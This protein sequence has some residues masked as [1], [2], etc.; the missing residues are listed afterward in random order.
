PPASHQLPS[1]KRLAT[2]DIL[3][4]LALLSM[5]LVHCQRTLA[6]APATMLDGWIESIITFGLADKDRAVFAL[7]FGASFAIM[8]M[9]IEAR[10]EPV[11]SIFVRR[12]LVLYVMGFAVESLTRFSILRELAWWGGALLLVRSWPT[13][14]LL[15]LAL[16][17]AAAFSIRDIAD[18]GYSVAT[19]G[20]PT[21][22]ALENARQTAWEEQQ[23]KARELLA[24]PDYADVIKTRAQFALRDAASL[25]RLIPNIHLSFLILGLLAVRHGIFVSPQGHLR[26]ILGIMAAGVGAWMI[27]RFVLPLLPPDLGTPRI[28]YHLQAGLGI[29][30]E[31]LLA[32]SY[33]G[34]ITLLLAFRPSSA[35]WLAPFGWAGRLALTIYILHV[36]LIEL[37][38]APHGLALALDPTVSALTGVVLFGALA[39]C[40]QR[41]LRRFRYGPVEYG[42]RILSFGNRR[43]LPAV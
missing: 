21:T 24:D 14:A 39:W 12:L 40:S 28:G 9:G 31:Q 34:A 3:R 32:L 4:G 25:S 33:V 20:H 27:A 23:H 5:I 7:L 2:L 19:R 18:S 41:W 30:D 38:S 35:R 26:L 36:A 6:V 22:I 43:S 42:W 17:S 1:G 11:V 8:M 37:A 15:T 16:I 10:G 29:I 13:R